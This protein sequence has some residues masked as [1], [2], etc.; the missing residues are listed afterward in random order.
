[1]DI[2]EEWEGVAGVDEPVRIALLLVEKQVIQWEGVA[3]V[4]KPRSRSQSRIIY[5]DTSYR[6]A[7]PFPLRIRT[8]TPTSTD[9]FISGKKERTC[10]ANLVTVIEWE[11]VAEVDKPVRLVC[12]HIKTHH[13]PPSLDTKV[14]AFVFNKLP[15]TVTVTVTSVDT[16]KE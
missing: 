15:V 12:V 14:N 8:I 4:D 10:P 2:G 7:P 3:G 16:E 11:G 13:M 9:S 6:K 1:V 5:L